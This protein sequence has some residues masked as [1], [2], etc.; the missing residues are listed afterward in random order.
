[1][2][3]IAIAQTNNGRMETLLVGTAAGSVY[4][5]SCADGSL[6]WSAVFE[7]SVAIAAGKHH[8]SVMFILCFTFCTT[9]R[10]RVFAL[11][12][13]GLRMHAAQLDNGACAFDAVL[14]ALFDAFSRNSYLEC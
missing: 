10:N 3:S 11:D 13:V 5:L 9:A 1:V 7:G 6:L 2:T 12:S 8:C 4:A 14:L